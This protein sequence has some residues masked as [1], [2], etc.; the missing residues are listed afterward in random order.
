MILPMAHVMSQRTPI[1]GRM[2]TL[3]RTERFYKIDHLIRERGTVPTRDF[4]H[5]LEVSLATL[6][7]DIEYM[8]SRHNAPIEWDRDAGGYRFMEKAAAGPAYE[9]PGLWFSPTEAQ[10]LLTMEHLLE[11]MEPSLLGAHVQPLK[12]RLTALLSVGDRS[13]Q[14]VRRRIR[15]ISNLGQRRH[16]PKHFKLVASALLGRSRLQISYWNRM[17][18]EVTERV[19]SPQRLVFYRN[20]WYLDAWCHLRNG[21]RSFALDAM[22]DVSTAAGKAREVAD[23]EIDEYVKS[24]YGIFSGA[25]V[26]WAELRFAVSVARYVALEEW[27][28][29]QRGRMEPDG[30]YILEV[31]FSSDKELVMDILRYG[32][33]VE[34]I[35]PKAL[36]EEVGRRLQAAA[37]KYS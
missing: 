21:L 6:K 4:L 30:T 23:A 19:V 34:V 36:R 22:K 32:P 31:P 35:G 11:G 3:D 12:A 10:A 2:L 15:V 16:Q 18:D 14:E 1:I 24:G 20:N 9:L 5:E 28:R 33:D 13:A 8:K 29:K 17:K 37:S 25:K 27:H 7:R 26:Q